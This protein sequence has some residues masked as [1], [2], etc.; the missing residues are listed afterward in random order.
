[1]DNVT[2]TLINRSTCDRMLNN[3]HHMA[4]ETGSPTN[5]VYHFQEIM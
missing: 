5:E 4:L 2:K 1:M 3:F